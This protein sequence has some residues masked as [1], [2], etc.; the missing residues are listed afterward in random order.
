MNAKKIK[1]IDYK[2]L[3]TFKAKHPFSNLTGSNKFWNYEVPI[4]DSSIV[5]EETGTGFVHMAPS[6]GAEDYEE[7]LKRGWL[8]ELTHNVNEDSSFVDMM[9][10]FGGLEI[11]NKKGKEGKVNEAVIQKLIEVNC[12]MARGRLNHS[13]PHSWRSKAPLIFRNTK[14]WFVSI[15]K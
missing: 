6:H 4:I 5:T 3:N 15:D 9:P 14:Q 12:L 2:D 13:Y 10:I 11:F 1:N 7:F 8:E